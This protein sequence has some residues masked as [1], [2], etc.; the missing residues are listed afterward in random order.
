MTFDATIL[1]LNGQIAVERTVVDH[2]FFDD[3]SFV[4]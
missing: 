2:I 1:E 4:A 3:V